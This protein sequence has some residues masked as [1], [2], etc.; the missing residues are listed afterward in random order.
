MKYKSYYDCMHK[1]WTYIKHA[2]DT[3]LMINSQM[4]KIEK[5][6]LYKYEGYRWT[7]CPLTSI[8]R[9]KLFN[10]Q[11]QLKKVLGVIENEKET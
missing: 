6:K 9:D 1:C 5:Q 3:T 10:F 4:Y 11:V 2:K 7:L 8:N